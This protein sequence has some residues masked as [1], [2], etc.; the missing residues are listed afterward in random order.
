MN[1]EPGKRRPRSTAERTRQ[2]ILDTAAEVMRRLGMARTTTREIARASGYSEATLYKHFTDKSELVLAVMRHRFPPFVE[3]LAA[4]TERAGQGDVRDN[5]V[6]LV[7]K[8]VPFFRYGAPVLG[9]LFGEPDLLRRHREGMERHGAGPHN[10]NRGF[11]AYLSAE[12]ELGRVPADVA[13]DAVAALL[14]GACFQRGFLEAFHEG[15]GEF[16]PLEEFAAALVDATGVTGAT[17]AAGTR[18]GGAGT[19]T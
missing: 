6:G 9:S 5:L 13:P 7:V 12:R 3:D 18:E 15:G 2:H 10:V 8:A 11:A 16:P 19:R 1:G 14:V 4:M 17:G